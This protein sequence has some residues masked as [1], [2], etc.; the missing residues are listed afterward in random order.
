MSLPFLTSPPGDTPVVV[1]GLFKAAPE[2]VFRAWTEPEE[3]VKW[4]GAAPHSLQT[5]DIDLREGGAW[6][7]AYPASEG[8]QSAMRGEYVAIEAGRRLI[9]TWQ[10]ERVL[11][12]GEREA[13]P[14]SQVTVTFEP[15]AGGT[16]VRLV[17]EAIEKIAGRQ[18]VGKGW[19]ASFGHLQALLEQDGDD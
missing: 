1:E 17:H 5:V 11:E 8:R 4:F 14:R 16:F 12:G 15:K 9:F 19:N 10:H 18:G 2:R 6:R 13:T 3:V 7:F